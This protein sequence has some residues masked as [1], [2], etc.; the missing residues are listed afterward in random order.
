MTQLDT[1]K[2]RHAQKSW[3]DDI[4]SRFGDNFLQMTE[5]CNLLADKYS[6]KP[7]GKETLRQFYNDAQTRPGDRTLSERVVFLLY[8]AYGLEPGFA[9][10]LIYN[11]DEDK[12]K[13]SQH[14]KFCKQYITDLAL[15][16]GIYRVDLGRN[17]GID[18]TTISRLFNDK[19][20]QG[21]Q[22]KQLEKLRSH[23]KY[24]FSPRF[25][26]FLSQK[27]SS[28]GVPIVGYFSLKNGQ[29]LLYAEEDRKSIEAPAGIDEKHG[30][31][32]EMK[33]PTVHPYAK[34]GIVV[35]YNE[36]KQGVPEDCLDATCIVTFPDGRVSLRLVERSHQ[37]GKFRLHSLIDGSVEESALS[38]AAK[39][40]V[41]I[42]P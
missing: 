10:N 13:I 31:A 28:D 22:M 8:K 11:M 6:G 3:L 15:A 26:A 38:S 24:N 34:D 18:E 29:V 27:G 30:R 35:F 33:G 12:A 21:L 1:K 2:L 41:T 42:Q 23:Y 37:R 9:T 4:Q 19:K 14:A 17:A 25:Q 20:P 32:V 16:K 39:L 36:S 5:A 40:A 7:V